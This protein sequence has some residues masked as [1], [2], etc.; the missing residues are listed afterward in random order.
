M[1]LL[2][3]L[4]LKQAPALRVD[5]RGVTPAVLAALSVAEIERLTVTHGMQ[6]LALAEL[7]SIARSDSLSPWERAGVRA[8]HGDS[9]GPQ[10][11]TPAGRGGEYNELRFIGD[12]SRF[13]R[14]GWQLAGGRVIVDGSVGDYVG[15][16][17]SAGELQIA[18]SAGALAACEMS[19]GLLTV[20]GDVGDFAASTLPGSMDGMRGGTF[21][22]RGNAGARFGDRMRRGTALVFGDAG[23]FLA[24][25]MVAGTI[26]LGGAAGKHVGYGMR[27]GSVVFAGAVSATSAAP[28]IADTFVPAVADALVFWQLLSRNLARHDGPF[29]GLPARAIRRHL[30]DVAAG[31]KGELIVAS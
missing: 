20:A 21:I 13:D 26:A 27:R 31:G 28:E 30:G 3:T 23:D 10:P 9:D 25:R 11:L 6:T 7:F 8:A 4:T 22:V 29:V 12:L 19:G 15:G 5:L 14:V 16:G 24:S 1:S 17:M 18:G 2:I